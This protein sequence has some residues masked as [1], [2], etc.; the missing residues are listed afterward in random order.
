MTG[1]GKKFR[2]NF[3]SEIPS[4][5]PT[6]IETHWKAGRLKKSLLLHQITQDSI[7][8]LWFASFPTT[9]GRVRGQQTDNLC[10]GRAGADST[11]PQSFSPVIHRAFAGSVRKPG[12][13]GGAISIA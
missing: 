3:L 11:Q 5:F 13:S 7:K 2:R 12:V 6:Q 10:P 1:R 8:I 4:G 9:T